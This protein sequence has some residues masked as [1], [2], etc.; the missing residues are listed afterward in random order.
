MT[1]SDL[2]ARGFGELDGHAEDSDLPQLAYAA[3]WYSRVRVGKN[4]IF[5]IKKIGF[6]FKSNISI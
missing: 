2:R 4:V 6:L 5:K 1:S 3:L